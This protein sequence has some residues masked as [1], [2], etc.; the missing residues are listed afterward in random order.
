[1]ELEKHLESMTSDR[2]NFYGG[3]SE[4]SQLKERKALNQ[5]G[6][7][8]LK[9]EEEI[10]AI[11]DRLDRQA[12]EAARLQQLLL[13]PKKYFDPKEGKFLTDL[14]EFHDRQTS[15]ERRKEI[16]KDVKIFKK[17]AQRYPASGIL[18]ITKELEKTIEKYKTHPELKWAFEGLHPTIS[19]EFKKSSE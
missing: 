11:A 12:I 15:P 13:S 4:V 17:E 10:L 8:V 1:D 6:L 16:S 2:V 7:A 19:E 3:L 9:S 5:Q 14:K 18:L